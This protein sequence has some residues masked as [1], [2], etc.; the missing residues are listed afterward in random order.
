MRIANGDDQLGAPSTAIVVGRITVFITNM[1]SV[2]SLVT[3]TVFIGITVMH[4]LASVRPSV[5]LCHLFSNVNHH[6]L[7]LRK[8]E[9]DNHITHKT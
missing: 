2:E 6:N 5:C 9:A 8:N 1:N 3:M 4:C 7:L